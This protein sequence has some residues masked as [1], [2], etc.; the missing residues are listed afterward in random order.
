MSYQTLI[1]EKKSLVFPVMCYSYLTIDYDKEIADRA[2]DGVTSDDEVYGVFGHNEPFTI[3]TILTPYDVNGYKYLFVGSDNPTGKIGITDSKKTV[4]VKQFKA[5][6]YTNASAA[7]VEA[8]NAFHQ[9]YSYFADNNLTHEMSI[10]YSTNVQLS[11]INTTSIQH[12]QPAEYKIRFTIVA[13]GVSDSL[14]S[15]TVITA[16]VAHHANSGSVNAIDAHDGTSGKKTYEKINHAITVT[17]TNVFT[18]SG[19]ENQKFVGG[20]S[21]VGYAYGEK[22]YT[23]SGQTFT[24]AGTV[25]YIDGSGVHLEAGHSISTGNTLYREAPKE[26]LY[27]I[28]PHHIGVAFDS[29][30]GK[31]AIYLNNKQIA[32]KTHSEAPISSFSFER[33]DYYIGAKIT[34]TASTDDTPSN[35]NQFMGELHEFAIMKGFTNH[36][37]S[38]DTLVPQFRNLLLYYR[39]EE[40]DL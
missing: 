12:N 1:G 37:H 34:G 22:L 8:T 10:F 17:G 31:M 21:S 14:D 19:S 6:N 18:A 25:D 26:A 38:I 7:S 29:I 15:D 11:L 36:F 27:L 20:N 32:T 33:E 3:S 30:S 39:F 35:R 4:P 23:V 40:V 9:Q 2:T 5:F 13:D 24:L 16:N 28:T